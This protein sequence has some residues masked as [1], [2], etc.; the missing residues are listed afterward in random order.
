MAE[1]DEFKIKGGAAEHAEV[2]SNWWPILIPL[3]HS[4]P[5]DN[6][7][8]SL[9]L[10]YYR[11]RQ[12]PVAGD[13]YKINIMILLT[14]VSPSEKRHHQA[15]ATRAHEIQTQLSQVS[16]ALPNGER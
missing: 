15:K 13:V 1:A 11:L 14:I 7:T 8:S 4:P 3:R 16:L 5:H 6:T 12:L 2:C 9:Q 10:R